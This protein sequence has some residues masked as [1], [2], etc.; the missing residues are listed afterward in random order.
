MTNLWQY[1]DD[2]QAG[3]KPAA[4]EGDPQ[5]G[6]YR[7]PQS[8]GYLGK[9]TFKPV[10]Y[11]LDEQHVMRCREGDEDVSTTR[12][13]EIW[14]RVCDHDISEKQWREV[15]DPESPH[16]TGRWWD[17][18]E[19]VPMQ[20]HN[21]PPPP[22][23]YEDLAIAIEDLAS[24]VMRRIKGPEI[25]TQEE[26]DQVANLADRLAELHKLAKDKQADEEK[27]WKARLEDVKGRWKPLVEAAEL[28]KQVKLK[29]ITPWLQRERKALAEASARAVAAGL[30]PAETEKPSAGT[31]GRAVSLKEFRSIKIVDF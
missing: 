10:V 26:C 18:S 12:G 7:M 21:Q 3:K 1:W 8:D 19:H 6:F 5:L 2:R 20:K 15:A 30:V 28:Y 27:P 16:Y 4:S 13:E 17:E 31:R 29:L 14:T 11:Y 9:K 23:S 22:D 25:K 24:E